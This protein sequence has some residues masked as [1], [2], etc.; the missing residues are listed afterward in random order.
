MRSSILLSGK[1]DPDLIALYKKVGNSEFQNLMKEALRQVLGGGIPVMHKF[2][3]GLILHGSAFEE[4]VKIN[5]I[6]TSEKDSDVRELLSHILPGRLGTFI[7]QCLRFYLGP[8]TALSG[9]LDDDFSNI[10]QA[11]PVPM[12]VFSIGDFSQKNSKSQRKKPVRKKA[13]T[14][15][16]PVTKTPV[17]A[18]PE[19][20]EDVSFTSPIIPKTI[21]TESIPSSWDESPQENNITGTGNEEDDMLALLEGLLS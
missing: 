8:V 1:R 5:F 19:T 6:L 7:K 20:K 9:F 11:K 10:L 15:K 17:E 12:Q 16:K 18:I 14:P 2:P 13:T 21:I 3:D 4:T